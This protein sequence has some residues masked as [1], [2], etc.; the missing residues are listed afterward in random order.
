M[1]LHLPNIPD[2]A[3]RPARKE[4]RLQILDHFLCLIS[5]LLGLLDQ[6]GII[7]IAFAIFRTAKAPK[8]HG[9]I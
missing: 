6:I 8:L 1:R 7:F 5:I 2:E 9:F 3:F 4:F